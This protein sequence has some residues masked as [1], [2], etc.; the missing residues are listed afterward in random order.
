MLSPELGRAA[1]RLATFLVVVSLGLLLFV[2]SGSAEYV[3]T[4]VTLVVGVLL[5]AV[6]GFLVRR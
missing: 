6:V 5:G 3:V 4:V 1:F 2:E